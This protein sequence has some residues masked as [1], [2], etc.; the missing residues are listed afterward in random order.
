M[1]F[2]AQILHLDMAGRVFHRIGRR[3]GF[4]LLLAIIDIGYGAS[5]IGPSAEAVNLS[6]TIWRETY[7]P[8]WVW[9]AGWLVV[10]AVLIVT[11]FLRDD[12]IGYSAAIGWKLLWGLT[13][14]ASWL[15]GGVARG[16]VSTIIWSVVAGMVAVVAGWPEPTRPQPEGP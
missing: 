5:L 10:A 3:G 1:R 13:T 15:F 11:A 14:L 9:G 2:R 16:W 7:A 8:L 6:T 12:M 4:L